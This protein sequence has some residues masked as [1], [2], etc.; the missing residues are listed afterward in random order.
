MALKNRTKYERFSF[1]IGLYISLNSWASLM[2]VGIH[3]CV[4]GE[5]GG[6]VCVCGAWRG[7]SA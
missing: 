4:A 2:F 7:F 5:G 1:S 3:V 6:T